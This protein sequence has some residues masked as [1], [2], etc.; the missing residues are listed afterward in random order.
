MDFV[1]ITVNPNMPAV[2]SRAIRNED[3]RCMSVLLRCVGCH[4]LLRLKP[5]IAVSSVNTDEA[6]CKIS[7]DLRSCR[8]THSDRH[9]FCYALCAKLQIGD[10]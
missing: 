7:T 10:A 5:V 1:G 4:S 6:R 3:D 8:T 2:R 9:R